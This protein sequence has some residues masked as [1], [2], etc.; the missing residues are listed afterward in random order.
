[1]HGRRRLTLNPRL[2]WSGL[3][4][5]RERVMGWGSRRA[6]FFLAQAGVRSVSCMR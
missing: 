6:I 2:G 4:V 3:V 1:M 5:G